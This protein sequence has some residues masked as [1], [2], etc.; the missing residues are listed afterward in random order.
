VPTHHT[1]TGLLTPPAASKSSLEA[2]LLNWIKQWRM[3][4]KKRILYISFGDEVSLS[5][6]FIQTVVRSVEIA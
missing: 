3:K 6:K 1:I 5:E 4:G 2:G